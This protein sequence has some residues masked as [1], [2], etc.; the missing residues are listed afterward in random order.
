MVPI[1]KLTSLL[2]RTFSKPLSNQIKRYA[3]NKH[4]S[5]KP[6]I[7]KTSFIFIGNKY[8]NLE[9]YLNRKSIGMNNQEVFFKPLS[10]EA[11]LT[12]GSD[13]FADIFVYACILGIPLIELYKSQ[14]ESENKSQDQDIALLQVQ[15]S[16]NNLKE[17]H[18]Q[19]ENEYSKIVAENNYIEKTLKHFQNDISE[20]VQHLKKQLQS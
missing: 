1:Q 8:H 3:L 13:L 19:F 15:T 16:I 6:S 2:I 17:S 12:K 5:R 7:I 10:D 4:R 18:E 9:K 14:K 20:Q 11:A